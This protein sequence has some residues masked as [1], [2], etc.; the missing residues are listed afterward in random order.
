VISVFTA[1]HFGSGDT[2]EEAI[3][4]IAAEIASYFTYG[5]NVSGR[6]SAPPP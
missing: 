5:A 4:R 2:L 3:G 6:N 1:N